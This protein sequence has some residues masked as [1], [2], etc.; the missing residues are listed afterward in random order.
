M[1]FD[2]RGAA[3][4]IIPR[5]RPVGRSVDLGEAWR[6]EKGVETAQLGRFYQMGLTR[7]LEEFRQHRSAPYAAEVVA[8]AVVEGM[9]KRGERAARFLDR[10]GGDVVVS[11]RLVDSCLGRASDEET[12]MSLT[13][14]DIHAFRVA[15]P[16][17]RRGGFA[18]LDLALAHASCGQYVKAERALTV[19]RGLVGAS[20]RLILRAEARLYQHMG[21]P[22]RSLAA[23]RRDPSLLFADPWLM[24]PE[25]G[26][27]QLVGKHSRLLR[28]ARSTLEH[29]GQPPFEISELAAAV[30]TAEQAAGKHRLAR[31][32][33]RLAVVKPAE[34]GLAQTVWAAR[35]I[36]QLIPVPD[37]QALK[38]SAEACARDALAQFRWQEA[39]TA[40]R[41]WHHEEPFATTPVI[42]LSSLLSTHLDDHDEAIKA[43]NSGLLVNPRHPSL[44]NNRAFAL[45][46]IGRLNEAEA[47]I[48]EIRSEGTDQNITNQICTTAT[49]GLIALRRG[50]SE[51]GE[52]LYRKSMQM[53]YDAQNIDLAARAGI[54]LLREAYLAG[55]SHLMKDV[56]VL[57]TVYAKGVHPSTQC[58]RKKI[59]ERNVHGLLREFVNQS[60]RRN[61]L[62]KRNEETPISTVNMLQRM[63]D[64]SEN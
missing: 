45:A 50:E 48:R 42:I 44:L 49:L 36:D 26:L 59:L 34:L 31:K 12:P 4:N 58:L 47:D 13:K 64:E 11:R 20:N 56:S 8:A 55:L 25:I 60:L 9:P 3:R 52:H 17:V 1:Q 63:P 15:G 33:F 38:E 29:G 30:A 10:Y 32:F 54:F 35:E 46:T 37:A 51:K 53:A 18:W 39:Q 16:H 19:A 22:D 14:D 23:L 7:A 2:S 6:A 5:W 24:A 21:E 62:R 28:R 40:C 57:N 61:S 41:A 43:A 27:S